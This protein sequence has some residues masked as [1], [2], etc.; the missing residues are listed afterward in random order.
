MYVAKNKWGRT[1]IGKILVIFPGQMNEML[2]YTTPQ[3]IV[4]AQSN[5]SIILWRWYFLQTKVFDSSP[6]FYLEWRKEVERWPKKGIF[7]PN[8][9]LTMPKETEERKPKIKI[10]ISVDYISFAEQPF[11]VD[12]KNVRRNLPFRYQFDKK[13]ETDLT[14]LTIVLHQDSDQKL[15]ELYFAYCLLGW[16]HIDTFIPQVF[17]HK[18]WFSFWYGIIKDIAKNKEN[19]LTTDDL[20]DRF[21]IKMRS[22]FSNY[23]ALSE[24]LNDLEH[25]RSKGNEK[26]SRQWAQFWYDFSYFFL[27]PFSWYLPLIAPL[28]SSQ[29]NF[30]SDIQD[31]LEKYYDGQSPLHGPPNSLFFTTFGKEFFS[32]FKL[33]GFLYDLDDFPLN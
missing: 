15:I 5:L 13:Y 25:I 31:I 29:E 1:E 28:F 18:D 33:E 10:D 27:L 24:E 9:S 17:S 21:V 7:L 22:K 12:F 6:Y 4:R 19:G 32:N 2:Q 20:I 23:S 26:K 30:R 11:L 16:Y 14:N 8:T 3:E